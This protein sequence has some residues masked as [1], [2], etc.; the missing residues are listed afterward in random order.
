[1]APFKL[2]KGYSLAPPADH[3]SVLIPGEKLY[4]GSDPSDAYDAA[5]SHWAFC[6]ATF[7]GLFRYRAFRKKLGEKE[8]T[9]MP[10]P[11]SVDGRGNTAIQWIDGNAHYMAW[12]GAQFYP[13]IVPDFAPFP[14]IP[15]LQAQIDALKGGVVGGSPAPRPA[16]PIPPG[17][18]IAALWP[19][20]YGPSEVDTPEE[21]ALRLSKFKAAFIE[22]L[23]LLRQA[24]VVG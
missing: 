12:Q 23:A 13:N 8:Y 5:N 1:M 15:S 24:G 20:P 7:A 3:P 18:A 11:D 6:D 14:S 16:I 10:L 21:V 19:L 4:G 2:P 9:E 22:L 17:G